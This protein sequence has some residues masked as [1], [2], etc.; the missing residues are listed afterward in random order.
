VLFSPFLCGRMVNRAVTSVYT[1]AMPRFAANLSMMYTDLAFLDRFEAA[2]Q[3]GFAGVEYLF[4]Y[5][6]PAQELSERLQA[7]GLQ[8][9]LFN[10]PPGGA[11]QQDMVRSWDAGLRGTACIP[12]MEATF[13]AGIEV[14]LHYAQT[15][16][17]PRIHVMAGLVP[18]GADPA[19]LRST[20]V[21]NMAWAADAA[22]AQGCEVLIEPIN[23]RDM[24]GYYLHYLEQAHA[25]VAAVG[26]ANLKVQMDLYHCQ[27]MEGD[28]TAKLQRYLP[29]GA[30]GHVQIASVPLRQEPDSGEL[31]YP[32]LFETLD[33]LGYTGWVGCEYR[34]RLGGQA[35]GT[36]AGLGWL[37][38]R[39]SAV[40]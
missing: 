39:Q 34:P 5:A 36:S 19:A 22:V 27:I 37:R 20:Y 6:Y 18:E 28:L 25:L 26:A 30:V 13:R 35:G 4:P 8:Q 23:L 16:Q 12:G 7:F 10:A 32:H 2:A 9:V 11:T 15:L 14:A 17:C 29:T 38:N 33:A 21:A 3:D 31:N 24:P 40:A 1:P